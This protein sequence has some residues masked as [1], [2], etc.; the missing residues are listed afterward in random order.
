MELLSII[1]ENS[2]IVTLLLLIIILLMMY[3]KKYFEKISEIHVVSNN[4]KT[5]QNELKEN[6]KIVESI[7]H[8]NSKNLEKYKTE[9]ELI[10]WKSKLTGSDE[11]SL[12]KN[13]A[14]NIGKI[15]KKF[16]VVRVFSFSKPI[17]EILEELKINYSSEQIESLTYYD[18]AYF[19]KIHEIREI[20]DAL[21]N[22]ELLYIEAELFWSFEEGK[23]I[24]KLTN[25]LNEYYST[26]LGYRIF[27]NST[28]INKE[29][30]DVSKKFTEYSLKAFN[31]GDEIEKEFLEIIANCK[32]M[33]QVKIKTLSIPKNL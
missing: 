8:E 33:L 25:F 22:L 1:K 7:R 20:S 4:I 14:Y 26:L 15:E 16:P 23:Y 31:A 9:I 30:H 11:Y 32:K 28:L 18:K 12:V 13:L 19:S 24:N 3:F 29:N 21:N 10:I 2:P 5:L 17:E 27:G 6:T